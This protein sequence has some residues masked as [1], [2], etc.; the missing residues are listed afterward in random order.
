MRDGFVS[1]LLFGCPVLLSLDMKFLNFLIQPRN[2][3]GL[4]FHRMEK[5]DGGTRWLGVGKQ[6]RTP[7]E[8]SAQTLP[9]RDAGG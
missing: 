2:G 3:L 6:G 7:G 1:T 5:L 4:S 9:S 8:G